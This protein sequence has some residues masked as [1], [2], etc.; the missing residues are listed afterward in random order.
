MKRKDRSRVFHAVE[1]HCGKAS[2]PAAMLLVG[3]RFL[4]RGAPPILPL[5]NCDR[6]DNCP[7]RYAHHADRRDEPRRD[8]DASGSGIR[9]IPDNNR[10]TGRGRRRED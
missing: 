2:C 9:R 1:I 5:S 6:P 7:C 4:S 3:R 8:A 10:R